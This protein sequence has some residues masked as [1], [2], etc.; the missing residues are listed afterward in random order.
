MPNVFL[1]SNR[2]PLVAASILACDFAK[3]GAE[4]QT[5]LPPGASGPGA[6]DALHL[7]VMDG[8]FVPNLTM[9]PD[10]ARALRT[11]FPDATLDAHLMVQRPDQF[12]EPFARAGVDHL[13][14][15]IEP[16]AGLHDSMGTVRGEPLFDAVELAKRVRQAGMS[17]GVAVNPLTPP[18]LLLPALEHVDL[19][20]VMSVHPGFAGQ[21]FIEATLATTRALRSQ[22]RDEQRLQ[23]DGGLQ[24]TNAAAAIEAGCDVLVAASAIFKQPAQER[25]AAVEA[26]RSAAAAPRSSGGP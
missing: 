3:L 13:T 7:D 12:V 14:F 20:L 18:D 25:P 21:R 17:V 9:G 5:V 10:V 19:V 1:D 8:H 6:V 15:H 22:L 2:A 11:A 23:M 24:P 4:C 16:A 26:L